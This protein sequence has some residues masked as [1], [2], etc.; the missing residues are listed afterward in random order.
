MKKMHPILHTQKLKGERKF[1]A[2]SSLPYKHW[3][4]FKVKLFED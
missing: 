1:N 4:Y 2:V 3:L